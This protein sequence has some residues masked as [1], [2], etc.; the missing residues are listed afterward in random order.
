MKR[1]SRKPPPSIDGVD[2]STLRYQTRPLSP[3]TPCSSPPSPVREDGEQDCVIKTSDAAVSNQRLDDSTPSLAPKGACGLAI[4]TRPPLYTPGAESFK[5]AMEMVDIRLQPEPE[6]TVSRQPDW[7]KP[8]SRARCPTAPLPA[9]A[10]PVPE[11]QHRP[12]SI[13]WDNSAMHSFKFPLAALRRPAK[14]AAR[15]SSS[16]TG[17]R[18]GQTVRLAPSSTHG[19][20]NEAEGDIVRRASHVDLRLEAVESALFELRRAT[21]SASMIKIDGSAGDE[22]ESMARDHDAVIDTSVLSLVA[23]Q[24]QMRAAANLID[25][26]VPLMR[27]KQDRGCLACTRLGREEGQ[28]H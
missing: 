15:F 25:V 28:S 5:T 9:P 26:L 18:G 7:N 4:E 3:F 24:G 8:F 11:L 20:I 27:L 21:D 19:D 17:T 6:A 10:D 1:V 13:C 23:L 16:T 2:C 12:A 22:H 14:A